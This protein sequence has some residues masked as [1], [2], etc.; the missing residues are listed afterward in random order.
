[1]MGP[2]DE[3][4]PE[5]SLMNRSPDA[6]TLCGQRLTSQH[7]CMFTE[8]EDEQYRI[9]NPFVQEG[10]AGGE[11]ILTIVDDLLRDNHGH[12]MEE[13]GVP[14]DDALASG[15]LRILASDDTYGRDRTFAAE[16]M[17][18]LL[19]EVLQESSR[20]RWKRMRIIGDAGWVL[21][22]MQ[23]SDE[24]MAYEAKVNLLA[25]KHDCTLLCIYDINKCSGQVIADALATHSHVILGGRLHENPHYM[26]PI[27]FLQKITLRR[28]H[29]A[30][31]RAPSVG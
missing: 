15:Q 21:R 26:Q 22:N 20:G 6:V 23:G 31:V 2:L 19:E 13:G 17:Y 29:P 24:L 27:D 10:L 16:R 11:E 18:D 28:A 30:P 4:V 9:L 7:V 5:G 3:W 25:P 14:V 8:S 1:M 12:R